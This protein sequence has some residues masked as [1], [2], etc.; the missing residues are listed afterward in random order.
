MNNILKDMQT[1][2]IDLVVVKENCNALKS[3][4]KELKS[5]IKEATNTLRCEIKKAPMSS[6]MK[7]KS[8][9]DILLTASVSE[10]LTEQGSSKNAKLLVLV[11][12]RSNWTFSGNFFQGSSQ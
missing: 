4:V 12:L 6:H 7:S 10:I 3:D 2:I 1:I 11:T 5:E 9:T 8:N